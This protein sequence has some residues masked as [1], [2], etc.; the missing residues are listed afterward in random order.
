M[1]SF[2][3]L[4]AGWV[5]LTVAGAASADLSSYID[6][7]KL[8]IRTYTA[9]SEPQATAE[10]CKNYG[11]FLPDK[12]DSSKPLVVLIHGIDMTRTN[13]KPMTDRLNS[14]GFQVACFCYPEDQPIA[15]DVRFLLDRVNA[16]HT[17]HPHV[18]LDV[19][20]FSMGS[21][22]ARGYIEGNHYDGNV[23]RLIMIAPPNH[24]SP[25][26][27]L[28]WVAKVRE[29][30]WLYQY[31][32][33][34]KPSW[35]ITSGLCEAGRDLLPGSKFLTELNSL[36]RRD[37]V[38]YTI[39]EGDAH[40]AR[41]IAAE[42]IDLTAQSLPREINDSRCGQLFCSALKIE[43][44]ALRAEH[45]KSDGAVSL[46]S[47]QLDGVRDV[48]RVHADHESMIEADGSNPPAAWDAVSERL[49]R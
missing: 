43:S 36:P 33:R 21:L 10:Q 35:F 47:A 40:V 22:I 28:A 25:L 1:R 31:N 2:K 48:V 20:A 14:A 38:R 13:L 45:D 6:S 37:G 18:K 11:L 12:I 17:D 9:V 23:D 4:I 44:A 19:V 49:M 24:G 26:A 5:V 42:A 34:W 39:I 32:P 7:A 30:A 41:R 46:D 3:A 8:A 16:L 15:D 29:Q 27:H